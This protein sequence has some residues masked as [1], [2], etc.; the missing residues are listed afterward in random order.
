LGDKVN[1]QII[2]SKTA[3]FD[4]KIFLKRHWLCL[5]SSTVLFWPKLPKRL[6]SSL[7]RHVSSDQ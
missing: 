2:S 6:L 5:L 3:N 1:S 7:S 4:A